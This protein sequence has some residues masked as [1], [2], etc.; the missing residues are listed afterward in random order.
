LHRVTGV[1]GQVHHD[2]FEL[3]GSAFTVPRSS[4]VNVDGNALAEAVATSFT[5]PIGDWAPSGAAASGDG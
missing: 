4:G 2:V 5:L 1:H 3:A